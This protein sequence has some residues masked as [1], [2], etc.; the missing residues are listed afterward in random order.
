[1][2]REQKITLSL[3]VIY[4]I[5]LSWIILFK[6][7]FSLSSLD[8]RRSVNLIPFAGSVLVNGKID[9]DEIINNLIVFIPVGLYLGML[10]PDWSFGKKICP[11]FGLS[12]TYEVLQFVLAIGA[13]DVTDFISNT[14]GG[15]VGLAVV[16]LLQRLWKEKTYK[17]LNRLALVCT[18]LLL[19]FLAFL[20][21]V[22]I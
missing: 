9:F 10:K 22:N 1:M 15:I 3:A 16:V 2:K 14:M 19:G 8:H 5:L 17:I 7:Q 11:V 13:T 6:M 21:I 4:L 18:V 12:L 20:L